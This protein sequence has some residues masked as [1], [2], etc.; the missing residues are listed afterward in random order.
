MPKTIVTIPTYNERENIGKLLNAIHDLGLVDLETLVI[1]DRSP[2]GTGEVVREIQSCRPG[3]HLIV[4]EGQRGRGTAGIAG[5]CRALEMGADFVFEMD[6]DFSHHPRYL[7]EMV[8]ILEGGQTDIVL[9]SR[10]IP[11]GRDADRP[12]H[13]RLI[14][15]VA[16]R[17]TRVCLGLSPQDVTS[18]YR[19]FR[20]QALRECEVQ[21][22][23]S[24]G[25]SLLQELLFRA[26]I[27]KLVI[28]ETPIEFMDRA[29]GQST[30]T[31]S[32]LIRSLLFVPYLRLRGW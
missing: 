26:A 9:G 27:K 15:E 31:L 13:R 14:S 25:P 2:D 24:T 17:Y 29:R 10:F 7:P 3:I 19:G 30:L 20:A 8:R 4:R 5:F 6:A 21:T 23:R 11:G 28:R 22:C 12:L 16:R 18:G 32:I 1:D